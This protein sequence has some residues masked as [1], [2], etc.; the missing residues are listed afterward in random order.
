M[1]CERISYFSLRKLQWKCRVKL[2]GQR[3]TPEIASWYRTG[4][5]RDWD[6]GRTR[7]KWIM[8]EEEQNVMGWWCG[9]NFLWWLLCG[10][11]SEAVFLGYLCRAWLV[12]RECGLWHHR[13]TQFKFK[14]SCILTM[15]F[16]LTLLSC[17]PS[18]T[19][20]LAHFLLLA[21]ECSSSGKGP[22]LTWIKISATFW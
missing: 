5:E 4:S 1:E 13:G 14:L 22:G 18:P 11:T 10:G 20:I 8:G 9:R 16:Y 19:C 6:V 7:A 21:K 12:A 15:S 3:N 2:P 17:P